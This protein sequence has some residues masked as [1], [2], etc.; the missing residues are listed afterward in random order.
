MQVC[1][2]DSR[3]ALALGI[4]ESATWAEFWTKSNEESKSK[5][6]SD[7]QDNWTAQIILLV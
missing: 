5:Q 2:L 6:V 3:E 1:R 4:L 7:N